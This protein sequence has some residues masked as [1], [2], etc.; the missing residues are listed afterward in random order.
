MWRLRLWKTLVPVQ[1]HKIMSCGSIYFRWPLSHSS[2]T[3]Y[4]ICILRFIVFCQ[5]I[6]KIDFTPNFRGFMASSWASIPMI[7]YQLRIS[8]GIWET[9]SDKV[10]KMNNIKTADNNAVYMNVMIYLKQTEIQINMLIHVCTYTDEYIIYF[11][12]M[13]HFNRKWLSWT[14]SYFY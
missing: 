6:V 5:D 1:R 7:Q 10:I 3:N 11:Q 12:E 9:K 14:S 4:N 13:E 2:L 8:V